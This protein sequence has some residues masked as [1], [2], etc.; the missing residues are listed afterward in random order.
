MTT[1]FFAGREAPRDVDVAIG[2]VASRPAEHNR[3]LYVI[4]TRDINVYLGLDVG[5][6]EYQTLPRP[7]P[8]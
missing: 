3:R 4:D 5:K 7:P 1:D 8:S 6:G 2:A